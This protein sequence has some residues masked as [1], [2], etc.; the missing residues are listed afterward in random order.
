MKLIDLTQTFT[1]VMPVYP[2]DTKP[3]LKEVSTV[4][5]DGFGHFWI[6]TGMHVG[7]HIDAPLHFIAGGKKLSEFPIEQFIGRGVL[8]EARGKMEIGVELLKDVDLTSCTHVLVH[9]DMSKIF[10]EEDYF[11][12]SPVLTEEFASALVKARVKMVGMDMNGPD[13][14]PFNV[15]KILLGAD[16]LIIENMTNL[17]Q[18][19]DVKEFE[20]IALPPKFEAEA[21]PTR[22]VARM[23]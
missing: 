5:K 12:N 7:T 13:K 11:A 4:E 18:L 10:R 22:V 17:D 3:E 1:A 15:H 16:V 14:P 2:G 23:Q 8:I 20:V 6:S 19:V 9:T 21:S